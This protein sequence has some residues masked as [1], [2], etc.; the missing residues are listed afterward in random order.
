MRRLLPHQLLNALL[1][2]GVVSSCG[3]KKDD[4]K[5]KEHTVEVRFQATA[6]PSNY[7]A[8]FYVEEDNGSGAT[9]TYM[10]NPS[11]TEAHTHQ[12]SR[13]KRTGHTIEAMIGISEVTS[14]TALPASASVKAD[15]VVDGAVKQTITVDRNTTADRYGDREKT[16]LLTLE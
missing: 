13:A 12:A 16:M 8:Q 6:I 4:A 7:M 1:L 15:I 9:T 14:G 10:D 11:G 2:C 3:D 5:P